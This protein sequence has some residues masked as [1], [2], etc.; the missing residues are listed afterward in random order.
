MVLFAPNTCIVE[1]TCLGISLHVAFTVRVFLFLQRRL[2]RQPFRSS[3]D[4]Q[5]GLFSFDR[6]SVFYGVVGLSKQYRP[7][8][9]HLRSGSDI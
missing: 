8:H 9:C 7:A 2:L 6:W 3:F 5:T 4:K 1:E